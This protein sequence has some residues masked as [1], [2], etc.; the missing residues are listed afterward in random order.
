MSKLTRPVKQAARRIGL[1]R[2]TVAAARACCER[3]V[4]ATIGR[5]RRGEERRGG[6]ILCYHSVGTPEWGVNDVSP[7]RFARHLELAQLAGY[8]F[9]RAEE[10]ARTG[11]RPEELA[12]TFDDGLTSVATNAAP[13]LASMDIPWTL[14]VVSGWADGDVPGWCEPGLL[15]SWREIEQMAAK[16]AAIGSHSVTHP[17]FGGLAPGAAIEEL[18]GSRRTIESRLG[19]NVDTFAIPFGQSGDWG[20][21][22]Q[23]AAEDA[24]YRLIYAQAEETRAAGTVPRTFVTRWDND[25]V[26]KAALGGRFDRWEEWV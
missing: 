12:I 26:F 7:R 13:V 6:R 17:R 11:G 3:N 15:M 25:R 16:G 22:T 4:M 2:A 20:E 10:I 19:V 24:G 18:A 1:R 14:F 8:R 21:A 9:V 5:N 23:H